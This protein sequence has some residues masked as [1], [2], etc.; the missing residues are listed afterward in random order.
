[1]R[2]LRRNKVV[3]YYATYEGSGSARDEYGNEIPERIIRHSDPVRAEA[4]ISAARNAD[5][6]EMFGV[7]L[8]YD[9]VLVAESVAFD[10]HALLW[11]DTLPEIAQDGSTVTPPDYVVRRI[12]KSLNSVQVAVAKVITRYA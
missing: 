12:V 8:N 1:M 10:E 2:C 7:E 4:N 3:Y 5:T 6:V 9:K 11:I